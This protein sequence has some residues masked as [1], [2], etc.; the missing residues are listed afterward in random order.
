MNDSESNLTCA[1]QAAL[2][3]SLGARKALAV[4]A[5]HP[6]CCRQLRRR[7]WRVDANIDATRFFHNGGC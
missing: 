2:F 5:A 3:S 6:N 7:I 1:I 4:I